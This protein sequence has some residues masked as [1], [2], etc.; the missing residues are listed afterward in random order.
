M[1]ALAGAA[2]GAVMRRVMTLE[3]V[4][5]ATLKVGSWLLGG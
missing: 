2:M 4:T 1:V 5:V 3:L